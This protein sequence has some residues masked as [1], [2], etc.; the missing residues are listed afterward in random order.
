MTDEHLIEVA[1]Q[2]AREA[3]AVQKEAAGRWNDAAL[4]RR[5]HWDN[6]TE[7]RDAITGALAALDAVAPLILGRAGV[8]RELL[9]FVTLWMCRLVDGEASESEVAGVLQHYPDAPWEHGRALAPK[10]GETT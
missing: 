10:E 7:V 9:D 5:G 2:A 8:D 1:K 6:L 4:I 3:I